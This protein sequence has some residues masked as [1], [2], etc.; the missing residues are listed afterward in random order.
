MDW[1]EFY[2]RNRDFRRYVDRYAKQNRVSV[3]EALKH[4]LVQNAGMQYKELE[5]RR[6]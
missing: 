5:E 4:K 2:D 1:K 3:D 6:R